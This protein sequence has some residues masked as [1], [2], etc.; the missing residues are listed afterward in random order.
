MCRFVVTHSA[1]AIDGSSSAVHIVCAIGYTTIPIQIRTDE[2]CARDI[3]ESLYY[4]AVITVYTVYYTVVDVV[5][6]FFHTVCPPVFNM[7]SNF[8]FKLLFF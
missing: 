6:S 5:R 7:L 1:V 3:T 4:Y 8:Q 2:K